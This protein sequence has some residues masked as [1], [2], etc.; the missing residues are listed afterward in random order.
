[1]TGSGPAVLLLHGQPGA[2]ADWTAV[3]T[4]LAA[5]FTVVAPDRPGYGRTGGDAGGFAVNADAAV[6][7]LDRL[8]IERA[9]VAGHSWGG[10]V[11]LAVAQRAPARVAGLVLVAS[12]G[13]TEPLGR[14]DRLLASSPFGSA[15]TAASFGLVSRLLAVGPI[16]SLVDRRLPT[17]ARHILEDLGGAGRP[18]TW[19]AFAVE[20]RALVRESARLAP[21]LARVEVPVAVLA[22]TSDHVVPAAAGARLAASIPRAT[23]TPVPGAGHLLP[24]DHPGEIAAAVRA[25]AAE[26]APGF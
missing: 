13:P 18:G 12:I 21:G 7:L 20:Q 11:A 17:P 3:A 25:V 23:F 10:G 16:R 15:M 19:R 1:V 24:L 14:L 6:A 5:D 9:V 22:G 26:T 8:N 4:E 2:A